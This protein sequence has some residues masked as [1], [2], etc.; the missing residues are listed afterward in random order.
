MI[1]LENVDS[2]SED[3][4]TKRWEE[5]QINKGIKASNPQLPSKELTLESLDPLT[6][7]FIYG[8]P[9]N[10]ELVS[11]TETKPLTRP[12]VSVPVNFVPITMESVKAKLENKLQDLKVSHILCCVAYQCLHY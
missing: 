7:S 10:N 9:Y 8:T 2:G 3:E 4:E 5:E 11:Q 1:A 12:P 6:Q